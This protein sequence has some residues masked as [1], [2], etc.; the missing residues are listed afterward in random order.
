MQLPDVLSKNPN[1]EYK[2]RT[3]Y[4]VELRYQRGFW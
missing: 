4:S 3:F 1:K 2:Q